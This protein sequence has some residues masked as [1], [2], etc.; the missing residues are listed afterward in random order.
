MCV[1]LVLYVVT[2]RGTNSLLSKPSGID[3]FGQL[4]D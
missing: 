1:A 3:K 2:A 4:L